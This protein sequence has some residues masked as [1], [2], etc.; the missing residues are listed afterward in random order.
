MDLTRLLAAWLFLAALTLAGSNIAKEPS[1]ESSAPAEVQRTARELAPATLRVERIEAM[2]E[3]QRKFKISGR[4][5][6][7]ATI[8]AYLRALDAS[9]KFERTELLQIMLDADGR[10]SFAIM[11]QRARPIEVET[12]QAPAP[13]GTN[14]PPQPARNPQ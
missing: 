11:V 4:A 6:R 2:G 3:D 9:A 5:D 7:N 10:P 12:A 8:S 1:G 13:A 14:A